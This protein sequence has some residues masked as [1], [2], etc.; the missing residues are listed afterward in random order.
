M[1]QNDLSHKASLNDSHIHVRSIMHMRSD[2]ISNLRWMR[3]STVMAATCGWA[4]SWDIWILSESL[5]VDLSLTIPICCTARCSVFYFWKILYHSCF[6]VSVNSQHWFTSKSKSICES[7]N[8]QRPRNCRE[9]LYF[10]LANTRHFLLLFCHMCG[11][12]AAWVSLT[13]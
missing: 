1:H 9:G 3:G 10:Y 5:A 2:S 6:C 4:V 8:C 12:S 7:M 13:Q 11:W